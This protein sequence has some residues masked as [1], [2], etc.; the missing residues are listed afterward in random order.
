MT[1][2]AAIGYMMLAAK[3]LGL[4]ENIIKDLD[5]T[6][7]AAMDQYTESQAEN[8]FIKFFVKEAEK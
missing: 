2:K 5:Y 1:N 6:M 8:V 7:Q 4:D 3:A